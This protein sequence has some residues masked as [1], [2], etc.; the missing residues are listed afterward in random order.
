MD[1]A[2]NASADLPRAVLSYIGNSSCTFFTFP[3][4]YHHDDGAFAEEGCIRKAD[5]PILDNE[6]QSQVEADL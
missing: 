5:L 3:W 2:K 6:S 1:D 4:W